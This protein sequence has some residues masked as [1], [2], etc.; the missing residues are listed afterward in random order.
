MNPEC[1]ECHNEM[2]KAYLVMDTGVK[3]RVA[4]CWQ[5]ETIRRIEGSLYPTKQYPQPPKMKGGVKSD[6]RTGKGKDR[7]P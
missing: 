3:F 4:Y 2:V 7:K 5:C 1:Y 6:Q